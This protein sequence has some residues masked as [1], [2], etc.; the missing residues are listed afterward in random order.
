[1]ARNTIYYVG[2]RVDRLSTSRLIDFFSLERST[3][4]HTTII[5]SRVWFPYKGDSNRI[6]IVRPPYF[7][8][9][10]FGK[11]V[12]CFASKDITARHR[13]IIDAGGTTDFPQ[14][15]PHI[16]LGCAFQEQLPKFN[17]QLNAEYYRTW[18]E[19]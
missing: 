16:T 1:M 12:L 17:I 2:L 13:E 9:V 19:E 5:Y 10:F 15:K 7:M 11:T 6:Y 3:R 18:E 14:Y 4:L 8:D